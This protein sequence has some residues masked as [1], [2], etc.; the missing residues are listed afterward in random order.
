MRRS[1]AYVEAWL[2]R[3]ADT[4]AWKNGQLS[5]VSCRCSEGA[6]LQD[7]ALGI[8]PEPLTGSRPS[9]D[10]PRAEGKE[11]AFV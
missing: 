2:D 10:D 4:L 3:E 8:R 11:F 1:A 9:G 6:S 5:G 7:R